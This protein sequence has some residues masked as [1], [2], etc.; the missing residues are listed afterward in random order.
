MFKGLLK[1]LGLKGPAVEAVDAIASEVANKA[2]GG[3]AGQID[4]AVQ[5]VKGEV[6][7]RK[8]KG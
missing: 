8:T 2:T 4:E 1:K 7:R 3:A 5:S 6:K